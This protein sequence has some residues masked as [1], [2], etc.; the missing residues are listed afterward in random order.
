MAFFHDLPTICEQCGG[1]LRSVREANFSFNHSD[2][3]GEV[4]CQECRCKKR[5]EL[6]KEGKM[7]LK[8]AEF[9]N[10][11][12]LTYSSDEGRINVKI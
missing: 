12:D 9:L 6:V 10:K 7:P 1:K 2:F 11:S 8:M 3:G 4:L 5:F